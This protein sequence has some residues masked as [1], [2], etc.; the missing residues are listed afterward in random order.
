MR[1]RGGQLGVIPKVNDLDRSTSSV[2]LVP[3]QWIWVLVGSNL[4]GNG[5]DTTQTD[6]IPSL[7]YFLN[8]VDVLGAWNWSKLLYPA[9]LTLFWAQII[10]IVS[11]ERHWVVQL[12]LLAQLPTDVGQ[13]DSAQTVQFLFRKLFSKSGIKFLTPPDPLTEANTSGQGTTQVPIS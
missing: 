8:V 2:W 11:A 6:Q 13:P 7:T 9:L 1:D 5:A 10:E 12:L 4:I 3:T